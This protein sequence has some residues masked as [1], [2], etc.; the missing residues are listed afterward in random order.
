VAPADTEISF[1]EDSRMEQLRRRGSPG[2]HKS[3]QLF[4]LFWG[5]SD[6]IFHH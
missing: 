3:Q 6:N 2:G 5:E 4:A 1:Q